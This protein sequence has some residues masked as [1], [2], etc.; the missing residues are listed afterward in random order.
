[1]ENVIIQLLICLIGLFGLFYG[2]EKL[3]TGSVNT[4]SFFKVKPQF[5]AITIIALGTSFPE[6]VVSVNAVFDKSPGIAWGNVLGS[7]ISNILLVLV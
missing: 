3:V 5:I 7:N 6:L 2:G 4:A 1:M